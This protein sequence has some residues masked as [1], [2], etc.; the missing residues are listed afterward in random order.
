M[1]CAVEAKAF[2]KAF[3]NVVPLLL[4]AL[5]IHY[6]AIRRYKKRLLKPVLTPTQKL[7][8]SLASIG[9]ANIAFVNML[10]AM[11]FT[12][13]STFP[14]I[15]AL[16]EA[17]PETS[18]FLASYIRMFSDKVSGFPSLLSFAM[19]GGVYWLTKIGKLPLY[20]LVTL[21]GSLFALTMILTDYC[22]ESVDYAYSFV[23]FVG[24]L[25]LNRLAK[26]EKADAVVQKT[27]NNIK[28]GQ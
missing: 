6:L 2:V 13:F 24:A 12:V 1:E 11:L 20:S 3:L 16:A 15:K 22:Y 5:V 28:L 9:I 7:N 17:I 23:G 10:L 19:F 26:Y 14:M 21:W 25:M 4:V 27:I 18:E 8:D